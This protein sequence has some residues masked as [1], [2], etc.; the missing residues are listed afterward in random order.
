MAEQ[1]TTV[2]NY[3]MTNVAE[4]L[5]LVVL[6]ALSANMKTAMKKIF[7]STWYCPMALPTILAV[8]VNSSRA[9]SKRETKQK[10][11]F[12]ICNG[13]NATHTEQQKAH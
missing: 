10:S 6:T 8:T 7:R 13:R 3:L 1:P 12:R 11:G 4:A 5:R 9:Q 2:A